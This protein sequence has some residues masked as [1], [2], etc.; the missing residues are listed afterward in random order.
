MPQVEAEAIVGSSHAK[1][2]GFVGGVGWG[3]TK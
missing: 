2:S 1:V 3:A